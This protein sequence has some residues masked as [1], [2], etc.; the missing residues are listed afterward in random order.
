MVRIQSKNL[1]DL[2]AVKKTNL[3]VKNV[4]RILMFSGQS[5][6]VSTIVNYDSRVI[7]DL[8]ILRSRNLQS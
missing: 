4:F 3:T 2:L 6:K 7:P 8:K 1:Y 5:Y